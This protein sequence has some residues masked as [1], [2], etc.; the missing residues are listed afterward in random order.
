[1]GT[2]VFNGI[3][4]SDLGVVVQTPPV[5][6]F[7]SKN[8]ELLQI[9]GRSGDIV[10]EKDSYQ[11]V[12]RTYYLALVFRK[13]TSFVENASALVNWLMSANGYAR[14]EDSYEPEYYRLALYRSSGD[15][16]NYNDKATTI[17]VSFECK[18]QRFL[19]IG[20]TPVEITQTGQYIQII[21]PTKYISLPEI[22]IDGQN[23]TL[24]FY[25]GEEHTVDTKTSSLITSFS[26]KGVIDSELQ[27]CYS[28]TEYLNN[29]V[30]LDNGFP[31][32]Y[33]GINWI[34][35]SG[36]T[37]TKVSIKPKWWTL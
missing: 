11:N 12:R 24:S 6:S 2:I 34:Y 8:Y 7:P 37:L 32:L 20:D 25:S 9:E 22:T 16:A 18:P 35:I 21:N 3:S 36:T 1:M 30:A 27:D 10:I 14:L 23:L 5:Y 13:N 33:P 15:L 17:Q 28:E 31:K 19:K 4:T 26:G 29:K